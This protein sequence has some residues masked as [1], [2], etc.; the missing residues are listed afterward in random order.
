MGDVLK[1]RYEILKKRI[2]VACQK[3]HRHE[4]EVH[5]LAVSKGQS[6]EAIV[7]FYRLGHRDFGE[8]YVD[9]LLSKKKGLQEECPDIVWHFIGQI[10]TNKAKKIATAD[11]VHS[12]SSDKQALALSKYCSQENPL[13]VLLQVSFRE[14]IHRGGVSPS[15]LR[16]LC[17]QIK[18]IK[19]LE[20]RGLMLILPLEMEKNPAQGFQ[21]LAEIKRTIEEQDQLLLP[22]LSMG[23]SNDF[24]EA[25]AYGATWV[26]IGS[27]LFG[28]RNKI[29]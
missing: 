29:K 28:T 13:A 17:H 22:E 3:A 21:C 20:L 2:K 5:L 14:D 9:E 4:S 18:A 16:Q 24:E 25:I 8:N 6:V 7:E 1:S 15:S 26:R 19:E 11:F 12:V 27:A 23:M 10:Q